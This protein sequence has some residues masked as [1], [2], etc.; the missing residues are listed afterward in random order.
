MADHDQFVNLEK[1]ATFVED[2]VKSIER[3][4]PLHVEAVMKTGMSPNMLKLRVVVDSEPNQYT[5]TEKLS[6]PRFTLVRSTKLSPVS[7]KKFKIEEDIALPAAG[8]N[9]YKVEAKVKK[10]VVEA[11]KKL[12]TWRKLYYQPVHMA[13]VTVP[14]MGSMEAD[15]DSHFIKF[16][17][18]D[19]AGAVPLI[20]NTDSNTVAQRDQVV[21]DARAGYTMDRYEPY[22]VCIYF[23]NMIANPL[24]SNYV[25]TPAMSTAHKLNAGIISWSGD[26]ISWKVPGGKYLWWGLTAADDAMNGGRGKWLVPGSAH[27]VGDDGVSRSI[28]DADVTIDTSKKVSG[29]GGYNH[30][31]I[32][33]PW[34]AK[35][36]FSSNTVRFGMT[37]KVVKGFSGG[38]S[39]PNVN[40]ITVATSAWWR[41]YDDAK[42]LQILNHEMG[43]KIGMVADGSPKKLDKPAFQYTGQGHQ[44]P[45]C[46]NNATYNATLPEPWQGTPL[47]VMFGATS[48]F[49]PVTGTHKPAP[50][51]FCPICDKLV[52]RLDLFASDL[53]GLK[54][55]V[56]LGHI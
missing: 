19:G 16:K 5:A 13:G 52:K 38:Y 21:K 40:I 9:K 3:A 34:G 33:L 39:E 44:G 53:P 14:S 24:N 43:H 41:P 11:A 48:C 6:N 37:L 29:L 56:R 32:H 18:K 51:K 50:S 30:L 15:Y 1:K 7:A 28:P 47:C 35:D 23:V 31:K 54:N 45:H 49:D 8:G 36:F 26:T 10:K 46:Q 25:V 2:E 55:S 17:M 4:G 20:T 27:Y 22:T 42:R 12:F